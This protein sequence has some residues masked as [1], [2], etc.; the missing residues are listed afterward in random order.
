MIWI[1]LHLKYGFR[2]L[3]DALDFFEKANCNHIVLASY[4]PDGLDEAIFYVNKPEEY[5]GDPDTGMKTYD[6]AVTYPSFVNGSVEAPL[7]EFSYLPG[8]RILRKR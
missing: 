1:I 6:L 8:F 2:N 5:E 7:D 3:E 4:F